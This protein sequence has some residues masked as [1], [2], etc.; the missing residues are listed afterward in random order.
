MNTCFVR[1]KYK[2]VDKASGKE[3]EQNFFLLDPENDHASRIALEAYAQATPDAVTAQAIIR[4]LEFI[5]E[6][7]SR[8]GNSG[9]ARRNKKSM[10]HAD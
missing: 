4:W 2:V 8:A 5:D 6:K 3:L 9:R 10:H 7:E 1:S